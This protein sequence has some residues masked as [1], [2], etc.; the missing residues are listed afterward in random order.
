M[1]TEFP[2]EAINTGSIKWK[3]WT[4]ESQRIP[5][6]LAASGLKSPFA[7]PQQIEMDCKGEFLEW[8]SEAHNVWSVLNAF[9]AYLGA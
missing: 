2:C 3:T 6:A 1:T 8:L 5:V 7:V 4:N 9:L